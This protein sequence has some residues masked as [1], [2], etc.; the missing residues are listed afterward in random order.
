MLSTGKLL[1]LVKQGMDDSDTTSSVISPVFLEDNFLLGPL[2]DDNF[3]MVN[4]LR[5]DLM[6]IEN[7]IPYVILQQLFDIIPSSDKPSSEM[8]SKK[9]QDYIFLLFNSV[10]MFNYEIIKYNIKNMDGEYYHLLD[11]LYQV[12][13]YPKKLPT[14]YSNRVWGFTRCAKELFTSGFRIV[15]GNRRSIADIK[16]KKGEISIPQVTLDKSC[17]TVLRNLI[18]LE[19]TGT[20]RHT[21]TS[22]VKLMSTLI[23]SK[24]DAYL[25]EWIGI[26][27][28]SN[29]IEDVSEFFKS[30]CRGVDYVEFYFADVCQKV[31]DY[32]VPVWSWRRAKGY[33]IIKYVEWKKSIEYLN[34]DYFH[35]RWSFIAF[36]A[37]SLVILL[38]FL[39]TF[40]TIRAYYPPYH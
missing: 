4:I 7:Q 30:L 9:L 25:L 19:H 18:A 32:Q 8:S 36:L 35:D 3:A 2:D 22:Y 21:V 5:N 1:V 11:M 33:L 34:R 14:S 24:E 26:I 29:E 12:S 37:A 31:E 27:K 17:D 16:F 23:R 28:K 40:Y 10:S 38:T 13:G 39:Q 6:L 20:G 15:C